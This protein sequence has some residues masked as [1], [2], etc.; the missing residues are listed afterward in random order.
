MFRPAGNVDGAGA[1]SGSKVCFVICNLS[2]FEYGT[3]GFELGYSLVSPDSLTVWEAQ[4]DAEG[5][6]DSISAAVQAEHIALLTSALAQPACTPSPIAPASASRRWFSLHGSV[7]PLLSQLFATA[8]DPRVG[9]RRSHSGLGSQFEQ[10]YPIYQTRATTPSSMITSAFRVRCSMRT[11][12]TPT[13]S[14]RH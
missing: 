13:G 4:F 14:P 12:P 11:P 2:L 3:L 10:G 6:D 8:V 1:S 9:D 7:P 5:N